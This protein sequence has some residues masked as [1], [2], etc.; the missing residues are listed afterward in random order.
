MSLAILDRAVE[1]SSHKVYY[2]YL[3]VPAKVMYSSEIR[4]RMIS[5]SVKNL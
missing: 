5:T 3:D 4:F 2:G 1:S